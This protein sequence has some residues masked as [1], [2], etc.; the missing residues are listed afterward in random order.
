MTANQRVALAA[1]DVPLYGE[2]L[3]SS[4]ARQESSRKSSIRSSEMRD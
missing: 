2:T 1:H 4:L 3:S